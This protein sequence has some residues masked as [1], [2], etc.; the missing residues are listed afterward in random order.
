[1]NRRTAKTALLAWGL[2]LSLLFS[3]TGTPRVA[4]LEPSAETLTPIQHFIVLMQQNHSFDNYFG[5]YPGA[6][7]FPANT[8]MPSNFPDERTQTCVKPFHLE[9]YPVVDMPHNAQVF[10]MEYDGGLMDGFV[11]TIRTH[12]LDGALAMAY[13]DSREIGYYWGLAGQYVLFDRY[14]SSAQA[15]SV[16]NRMFWISGQPGV[17][18]NNI[19]SQGFGS[20]P[21]IFDELQAKGISWKYYVANYDPT[22]NYR[23]LAKLSYLPPQVQWVP[24]LSFDR[25][26]DDP[27]L[28]SH[29]VDL[30][31]YYKDLQNGTL[32]AVSFVTLQ[33]GISEHPATDIRQGVRVVK[34][35]IQALMESNAWSS[36]A[37]LLT[38]DEAGGWYDHVVPPQVD[39]YGYGFRVPALLVSPYARQGFVDHTVLDHTSSLK[40]IERNWGVS[41]LASRD[42]A[43]H[44][45]LSAFDFNGAA[46]DPAF[47]PFLPSPQTPTREPSRPAIY[48]SYGGGLFLAV[49]LIMFAA[50]RERWV[51]RSKPRDLP[52]DSSR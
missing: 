19:P 30:S 5:T 48:L 43:A 14:F 10:N 39:G 27:T 46:R 17:T 49:L 37:F 29:I 11:R 2:L 4:A 45:F 24:L 35:M 52:E 28:S 40:F 6:D 18:T 20:M 9:T 31:Q 23:S 44:D 22:I 36:S 34:S 26:I 51:Q 47:V 7:G 15:G 12:N 25:F 42:A 3:G 33:G 8:C 1:M 16:P 21:T 13:Y 41:A 50:L 38:Y 32:P